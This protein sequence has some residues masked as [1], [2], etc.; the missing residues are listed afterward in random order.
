MH[1]MHGYTFAQSSYIAS[2][3][4]EDKFFEVGKL[5][6]IKSHGC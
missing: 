6:D 1:G 4:N 3:R 2:F 5:Y